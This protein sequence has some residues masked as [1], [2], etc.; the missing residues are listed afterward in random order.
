VVHIVHD[1]ADWT[2]DTR[3]VEESAGVTWLISLAL[4]SEILTK[5]LDTGTSLRESAGGEI[6]HLSGSPSWERDHTIYQRMTLECRIKQTHAQRLYTAARRGMYMAPSLGRGSRCHTR[7]FVDQREGMSF[8]LHALSPG[9]LE[10]PKSHSLRHQM[11]TGDGSALMAAGVDTIAPTSD[12]QPAKSPPPVSDSLTSHHSSH[13]EEHQP[14]VMEALHLD[15]GDINVR[16]KIRTLAIVSALYVVLF[17]AALDQ[18]II[19]YES[20]YRLQQALH[21]CL[22]LKQD[23]HPHHFI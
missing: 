8:T 14:Q 9:I 12:H 17:I 22:R 16:T 21:L 1:I 10:R 2:D 13:A 4:N 20:R 11:A 3:T 18:T 7:L 5:A 15:E 23:H 19:A 6:V